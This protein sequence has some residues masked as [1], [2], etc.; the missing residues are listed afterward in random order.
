MRRLSAVTSSPAANAGDQSRRADRHF[1]TACWT[2]AGLLI[3]LSPRARGEDSLSYKYQDYREEDGRISV[4]VNSALAEVDLGLATHLKVLGIIDAIAGATPTGEPPP[5]PDGQVPLSHMEDE[6]RAWS[7]DL[8]H[9]FQR[10]NVTAG[11]AHSRESDYHSLGWSL[12]TL[13]DFNQ[14][15][16]T[17]LLG[18][19]GTDDDV[20]AFLPQPWQKKNTYDVITG[21]TQ[22]V[23]PR[24]SVSFNLTFS[25]ATG[26]LSDPYKLIQKNVEVLPG[27][28]LRRTFAENRPDSRTRWIA[29]VAMNHAYP[30]VNGAVDASYRFSHDDFGVS[31]NTFAL[32]WLQKLG[33]KVILSPSIRYYQQ[34]A[35]NFY[36]LTLDG[37]SILPPTIPPGQPPFYSADYRISKLQTLSYGLKLVWTPTAAWQLDVALEK[38]D[39]RGRDGITS[40]TA[41]PEA[42]IFT[43][44]AK[45]SF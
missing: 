1:N 15:N 5:T 31:S 6:R 10:V 32:E 21:I 2:L 22:L 12:N 3:L 8:S 45:F 9:Q 39:M 41:Y 27:V 36:F 26:Y 42:N 30:Q 16:T 44:G 33:A 18:L 37:T 34:S 29:L 35:A 40:P 38:Y 19:A 17:L 14:K 11:F 23:D 7:A 13:T 43:V 28:F 4:R 20:L 24:T 25:R